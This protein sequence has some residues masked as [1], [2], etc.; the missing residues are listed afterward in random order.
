MAIIPLPTGFEVTSVKYDV[1]WPAQHNRPEF[2][3]GRGR[4]RGLPGLPAWYFSAVLRAQAT[5]TTVR[6]WR[7][8]KMRLRGIENSFKLPLA[9]NQFAGA[10]PTVTAV[11]SDG[12]S[13][14]LS[15]GAGLLDGMLGTVAL[16]SGRHRLF[17]LGADAVGNIVTFQPELPEV[18][19]VGTTVEFRNPYSLVAQMDTRQGWTDANG[20]ANFAF[21]CEEA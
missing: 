6:R 14:T 2:A 4:L 9:P 7:S 11:G 21:D 10:N 12:L 1:D 16:P 3:P 15:S 19:V 13:L 20:N 5:E 17:V 18:P 8:F